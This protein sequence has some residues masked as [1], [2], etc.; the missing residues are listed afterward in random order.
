MSRCNK[1][2]LN[3]DGNALLSFRR[4]IYIY[5]Y[6]K[7]ESGTFTFLRGVPLSSSAIVAMM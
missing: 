1:F 7:N 5:I 4:E 6:E 2:H 3:R